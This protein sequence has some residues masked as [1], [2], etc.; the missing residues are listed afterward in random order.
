MY[1]TTADLNTFLDESEI[2]AL[3]RDYETDGTDKMPIGIS[4]AENFVKDRLASRYD[5]TAEYAKTEEARSTTLMEVI[6][7]IAIWKLAAT[8]PTV[9]LD[10]KRHYNYTQALDNLELIA[11]G[12]LLTTLPALTESLGNAAVYGQST[13][14]EVIY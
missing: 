12:K 11:K 4:Y 9:Q 5:V 10:G 1:L 2:A 14:T 13:Q 6:A 8:F 3:K 7:H